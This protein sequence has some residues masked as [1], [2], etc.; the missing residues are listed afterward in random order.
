MSSLLTLL[1]IILIAVGVWLFSVYN[2]LQSKM[3]EIR[4][5]LSNL[6]AALKKR[7]DLTHQIIDIAKDYA[8]HEKI[9]HQLSK[10]SGQ[11][12]NQIQFLAQDFPQLRANETY[13]SL[14]DRLEAVEDLI[15]NCRQH[16]NAAV[17][18]YNVARN[19]FPAVLVAQKLSFAT[20][21][22]YEVD[23]P[24]FMQKVKIFERDDSET[25]Q[26]LVGDGARVLGEKAQQAQS[27][28]KSTLDST[29]ERHKNQDTPTKDKS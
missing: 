21:P 22:Y 8:D 24:D 11:S 26:K 6:Q 18:A 15:L 4:E 9:T 25:L 17:R 19:Q 5:Q 23:D 20:A 14:M 10:V 13:Q 28:I 29:R 27:S 3:Q 7:M 1:F 12:A 16:Y 2:N